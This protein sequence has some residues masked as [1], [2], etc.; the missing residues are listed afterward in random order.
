MGTRRDPRLLQGAP[1]MLEAGKRGPHSRCNVG[2]WFSSS[3]PPRQRLLGTCSHQLWGVHPGRRVLGPVGCSLG[4]RTCSEPH[5]WHL[6]SHARRDLCRLQAPRTTGAA[7][8]SLTQDR[9][10]TD[11]GTHWDACS[12]C[13]AHTELTYD[14]WSKGTAFKSLRTYYSDRR[15]AINLLKI[16]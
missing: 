6:Q 4:K 11:C 5:A 14:V 3:T 2:P 1:A 15:I 13:C 10:I 16:L 8:V 7:S 12:M 9:E